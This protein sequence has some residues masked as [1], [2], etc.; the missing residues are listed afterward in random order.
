MTADRSAR[1]TSRAADRP[2]R[3]VWMD[4]ARALCIVLVVGYHAG[5]GAAEELLPPDLTGAAS[6]WMVA[7]ELLIPLRMPL[8]F[9]ISGLLAGGAVARAWS[10]VVR[11]RILDYLWPYALWSTV[12][13]AT[14]W[15]R[16]RPEDPWGYLG[17]QLTRS[18]MLGSPYWFIGVLPIFF[19]L[20]RL[21]R[22]HPR[23]LLA[24]TFV[25]Y[26]LAPLTNDVLREIAPAG[27]AYGVFQLMDLAFWYVLGYVLA[28]PIRRFGDTVT[29]SVGLALTVGYAA[30]AAAYWW[31]QDV[32]AAGRLAELVASVVGILA[33]VALFARASSLPAV[34][35]FGS[36]VGRRTLAIY[37]VHPLVINAIVVGMRALYTSGAV[38]GSLAL[39]LALAPA[40]TGVAVV[41]G[42]GLD[43]LLRRHGPR[44]ALAAPGGGPVDP[45]SSR[46]RAA[47][48]RARS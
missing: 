4:G 9:V 46:P 41:A 6:A 27:L 34:A 2:T 16:Y 7:N 35:A 23:L 45:D 33:V 10:R 36:A 30:A 39:D 38:T 21:G 28:A 8:F 17:D 19:V 22:S 26:A 32:P 11:P 48:G 3:V 5:H 47:G 18:L 1:H 15:V 12:F 14:A 20:V 29:L 42:V 44:W 43:V 25:L 24:L 40:V 31:L 37:L 13:A